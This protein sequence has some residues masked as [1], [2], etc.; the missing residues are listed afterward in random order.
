MKHL[1]PQ[2]PENRTSLDSPAEITF[3]SDDHIEHQIALNQDIEIDFLLDQYPGDFY[4][5]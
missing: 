2:M 4:I 3:L 1:K 5:M